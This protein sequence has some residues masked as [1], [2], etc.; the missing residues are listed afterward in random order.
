M[1]VYNPSDPVYRKEV[2]QLSVEEMQHVIS[3]L[4]PRQEMHSGVR[5]LTLMLQEKGVQGVVDFVEKGHKILDEE[6]KL[7]DYDF[8][9]ETEKRLL[10]GSRPNMLDRRTFL[11]TA[12]WGVAGGVGIPYTPPKSQTNCGYVL[13]KMV[14]KQTMFS[15]ASTNGS[16]DISFP[17]RTS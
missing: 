8:V 4:S 11:H 6:G 3:G 12:G 13:R 10:K 5:F 15:A 17:R 14:A 16:A 1:A 7:L 9:T 2:S